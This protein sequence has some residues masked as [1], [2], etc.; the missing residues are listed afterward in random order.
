MP[1][2]FLKENACVFSIFIEPQRGT[3]FIKE[4]SLGILATPGFITGSAPV[5]LFERQDCLAHRGH[6]GRWQVAG[7]RYG[8]EVLARVSTLGHLYCRS[9]LGILLQPI[10]GY[11]GQSASFS[12]LFHDLQHAQVTSSFFRWGDVDSRSRSPS[13]RS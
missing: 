12:P 9:S 5:F 8:E 11:L 7:D 1:F 10:L 6:G 3:E 13:P 2:S 4:R